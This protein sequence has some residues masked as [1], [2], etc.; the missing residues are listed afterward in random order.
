MD[1][2]VKLHTHIHT[3]HTHTHTH[4]HTRAY[5]HRHQKLLNNKYLDSMKQSWAWQL[6]YHSEHYVTSHSKSAPN[7]EDISVG[8]QSVWHVLVQVAYL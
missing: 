1:R 2:A 4:T 5:T 8:D 6:T 7:T 3:H